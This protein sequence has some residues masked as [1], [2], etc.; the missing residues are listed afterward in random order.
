[1]A[2]PEREALESEAHDPVELSHD[3]PHAEATRVRHLGELLPGHGDVVRERDGVHAEVALDV[4]RPVLDVEVGPVGGVR[5]RLAVVVL[6]LAAVDE[7][8]PAVFAVDLGDPEVRRAGVEDHR[9]FLGRRPDLEGAEVLRVGV[10]L[11]DDV[12]GLAG[13]ELRVGDLLGVAPEGRGDG[14]LDLGVGLGFKCKLQC[15]VLPAWVFP[16]KKMRG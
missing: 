15:L 6:V 13:E 1:M 2:P 7:P 16:S 10:V 4:A 12:L 9:E 3:V 5:G 8:V 11:D 14:G